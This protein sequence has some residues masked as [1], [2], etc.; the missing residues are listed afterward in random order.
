MSQA[1]DIRY[2]RTAEYYAAR[3]LVLPDFMPP[4]PAPTSPKPMRFLTRSYIDWLQLERIP[5]A[6]PR[7][8]GYVQHNASGGTLR[9]AGESQWAEGVQHP[10]GHY[11][12][13]EHDGLAYE[14]VPDY[15]ARRRP[16]HI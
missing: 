12:R 11:Y 10:N 16:L 3:G 6:M 13:R 5:L 2:Q 15:L 7:N 8:Q 1:S 4:A 14:R 9:P